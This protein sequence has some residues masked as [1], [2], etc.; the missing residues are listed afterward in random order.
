MLCLY[1][2]IYIQAIFVVTLLF[3][4]FYVVFSRT[5]TDQRYWH[6]I[7]ELKADRLVVLLCKN[8]QEVFSEFWGNE[9]NVKNMQ[10][11]VEYINNSNKI[12]QYYKRY[13]ENEAHPSM[14]RRIQLINKRGKWK[15][16]EYFEH[17]LV[18]NKWRLSG[19]GWNGR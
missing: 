6:Q 15:W 2:T 16:W 17:A 1:L 13:I 3:L 4:L 9:V 14:E 7:S 5:M 12:Y 8:G 19:K 11:R 18:V 10:S